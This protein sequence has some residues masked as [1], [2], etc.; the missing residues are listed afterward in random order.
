MA[1]Q[2]TPRLGINNVA[3]PLQ[4]KTDFNI[5]ID[6][7]NDLV[8]STHDTIS[9]QVTL[10]HEN[11]AA[12]NELTLTLEGAS[13]TH[14][15]NN[16]DS[17]PAAG[18][19]RGRHHFLKLQ[20]PIDTSLLS[21]SALENGRTQI[22]IP[23]NFVV[24]ER[25]LDGVCSH[26]TNH[27]DVKAAHIL[28]P[29]TLEEDHYARGVQLARISYAIRIWSSLTIISTGATQN[30]SRSFGIRIAPKRDEE[31][32][33]GIYDDQH[34]YCLRRTSPIKSAFRR[35]LGELTAETSQ[36]PCLHL[37]SP[38][39]EHES[40]NTSVKLTY[41]PAKH[42][43]SPPD[44]TAVVS[45]LLEYTFFAAAPFE[46]LPRPRKS[47]ATMMLHRSYVED[48]M[49]SARK[50]SN[51]PWVKHVGS[52]SSIS[53]DAASASAQSSSNPSDTFF[54]TSLLV[55]LTIPTI[56]NSK[57]VKKFPP[58]FHSCLVSR[59]HAIEFEIQIKNNNAVTL[60]TPIQLAAKAIRQQPTTPALPT[61]TPVQIDRVLSLESNDGSP[62]YEEVLSHSAL[63]HTN[64]IRRTSQ[65]D[66]LP[67]YASDANLTT[68]Q[69]QG[70][71]SNRH[72]VST[73][74]E[75]PPQEWQNIGTGN[76]DVS[77]MWHHQA[78]IM[79]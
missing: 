13:T 52:P 67:E 42:E 39:G 8:Y 77:Y 66:E 76:D 45:K 51:V 18:K 21:G 70:A 19:A 44:V 2:T 3:T 5:A 20:H 41:V 68:G 36:P 64:A 15:G 31:P 53:G 17:G 54:T 27:E 33:L 34:E 71:A 4:N 55:P 25:M 37:D 61:A 26:K 47:Y 28:L 16:S 30:E 75:V 43:E 73:T 49:L 69:R 32:P 63:D 48:F 60:T 24:P 10:E 57:G 74:Y 12:I 9:G 1:Q 46:D 79:Q 29:P 72:S 58:S 56:H 38:L 35:V 22:H 65:A 14:V 78:K 62:E 40:I 6:G 11:D 23:F 50:L 7:G 59:T